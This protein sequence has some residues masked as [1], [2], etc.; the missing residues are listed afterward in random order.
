MFHIGIDEAGRGPAIGPLVV[1]ALA[2]PESEKEVLKSIG[3]KDSK[4]I[5]RKK[6]EEMAERIY[7]EAENREWG[8]GI[9]TCKAS[10]I[11]TERNRMDLNKLEIELF[12]EAIIATGMKDKSGTIQAVSYTH[13]TLPTKRIV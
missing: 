4:K 10:R 1:C 8:I 7:L 11:D 2:M 9:I 12:K 3:V 6:R 5:T 13:L